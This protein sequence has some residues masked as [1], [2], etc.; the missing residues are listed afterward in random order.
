MRA[1]RIAPGL[2]LVLLASAALAWAVG[3]G[4]G[5]VHEALHHREGV[6]APDGGIVALPAVR[7][8]IFHSAKAR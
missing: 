8:W 2:V 7:R 5:E 3:A 6:H 4:R 1:G